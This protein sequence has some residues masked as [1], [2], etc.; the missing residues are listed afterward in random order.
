MQNKSRF[1]KALSSEPRLKIVKHLLKTDDY[2]CYCELDDL[3]EKDMSVIYRHFRTLQESGILETRKR[4]K[5][6]EGRVKNPEKTE[7]ILKIVEEINNED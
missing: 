6:L 7:K 1:F 2:K 3:I 4:G 5:R